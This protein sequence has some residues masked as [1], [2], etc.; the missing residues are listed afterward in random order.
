MV[1][2]LEGF[3]EASGERGRWYGVTLET[4]QRYDYPPNPE[5]QTDGN[6]HG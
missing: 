6:A 1:K 2:A 5:N 4:G 3:E